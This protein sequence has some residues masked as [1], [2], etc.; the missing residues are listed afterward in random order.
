MGKPAL[1]HL[2]MDVEQ[3]PFRGN[4]AA[5]PHRVVE[6]AAA[7]GD[8]QRL[9]RAEEHEVPED[10]QHRCV[11]CPDVLRHPHPHAGIAVAGNGAVE[12]FPRTELDR[13][14][15][16]PPAQRLVLIEP[17]PHPGLRRAG[18]GRHRD[19]LTGVGKTSVPEGSAHDQNAAIPHPQDCLT[20]CDLITDD[21]EF[22]IDF[23]RVPRADQ[24]QELPRGPDT[25]T[26]RSSLKRSDAGSD[27][28]PAEQRI[29]TAAQTRRDGQHPSCGALR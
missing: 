11:E 10:R 26:T 17:D 27:T 19:K 2:N 8:A 14:L 23:H 25:A 15:F 22:H 20:L 4:R 29:T 13:A 1:R 18:H 3:H 16:H 7:T 6:A 5:E 12:G 28:D 24:G 9:A 21:R